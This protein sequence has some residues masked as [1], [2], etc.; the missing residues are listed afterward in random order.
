[1]NSK[2]TNSWSSIV[3]KKEDL[4][5]KEV[6]EQ[7]EAIALKNK[8]DAKAKLLEEKERRKQGY[9]RAMERK[10]GLKQ[11]FFDPKNPSKL[12]AKKGDFWCFI[13]QMSNDDGPIAIKLR[14]D[15]TI[16]E[17]FIN[18]LKLKYDNWITLSENS[19]D[20]C[21]FL[22][23]IRRKKEREYQQMREER[24]KAY[25][26]QRIESE[27]AFRKAKQEMKDKV[28]RGEITRKE[29]EDWKWIVECEEDYAWESTGVDIWWK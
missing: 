12:I 28:K 17:L 8:A 11:D 18:Y 29:Y 26:V 16:Q 3:T 22:Y 23:D 10:Y 1:M 14:T 21:K 7:N 27:K 4:I 19:E 15:E 13:V 24:E 2:A 9:I 6:S 5:V 25:E 20:D